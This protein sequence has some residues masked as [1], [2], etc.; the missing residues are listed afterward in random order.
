MSGLMITSASAG[1]IPTIRAD[2]ELKDILPAPPT[3]TREFRPDDTLALFTEVYDN[4][5]ETPH[6]VDITTTVRGNDGGV[7][8]SDRQERS[9]KELQGARVA[10][11]TRWR[12]HCAASSP[13]PTSSELKRALVFRAV[14]R[15]RRKRGFRF[16]DPWRG[17]PA[18]ARTPAHVVVDPG[19]SD[20]MF[21]TIERGQGS[22]LEAPREV[23]IRTADEWR[24]LW[25]EHAPA[26][27]LP[28][29]DFETATVAGVF[30]GTRPTAG[31]EVEIVVVHSEDDRLIIEYEERRPPKSLHRPFI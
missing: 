27:L 24:R 5:A 4:Q 22:Q 2:S 7:V 8:F 21:T 23:V 18:R 19:A 11:D 14:S 29:I 30:L 1:R 31:V 9:T 17:K 6:S 20:R 12:S 15:Q 26:R 13:V 25:Q 16:A 10:L 3:T 28:D